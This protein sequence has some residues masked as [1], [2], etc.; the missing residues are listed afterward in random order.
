MPAR[1]GTA[2]RA[3]CSAATTA[4]SSAR[5]S[6]HSPDA[7]LFHPDR[8]QGAQVAASANAST[9]AAEIG[10]IGRSTVV[11]RPR[12]RPPP[13]ATPS[14]ARDGTPPSPPSPPPPPPPPP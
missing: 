10:F 4:T 1:V 5:A 7:G 8:R 3:S 9:I 2:S 14:V 13:A 12:R 11:E 6:I